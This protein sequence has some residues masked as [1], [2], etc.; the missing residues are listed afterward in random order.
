MLHDDITLARLMVYA[1]FIEESK[2]CRIARNL[3]ISCSSDQS[4]PRFKKKVS[5]KDEP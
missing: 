1:Q 5:T 3:K 2:L 4:Q